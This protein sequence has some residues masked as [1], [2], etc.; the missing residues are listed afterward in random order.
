MSTQLVTKLADLEAWVKAAMRCEFIA[1]DTETDGIR[2]FSEVI[3]VSCALDSTSAF[4]VPIQIW[5]GEKLVVPWSELAYAEVERLLKE[6]FKHPK[7]ITHNGGFDAK[8]IHNTFGVQIIDN[9]FCDTQLLHHTVIDESPPHGL[10]DLAAKHISEDAANPQLDLK[11]SVVANGGKWIKGQRDFYK[12]NWELLGHYA[13][14]DTLYTYRLFEMWYP[15]IDKQGLRE[16][17]DKEVMPLQKVAYEMN[18]TGIKVNIPYFEKLKVDMENT[19]EALA[20]EIYAQA[21]DSIIEYEK[22][23]LKD[24]LRISKQSAAGKALLKAGLPLEWND[25]TASFLHAWY[26]EH[27]GLK[28]IF[29]LEST[30]DKAF[31]LYNVLKLPIKAYTAS[32]KPSTNKAIIDEL[33]EEYEDSSELLKLIKARSSELKLL[34]TYVIPIL[35]S[36]EDGKIYPSF[37][38]TGTTSGRF[39]CGGDSI[40]LQTL[41]RS[42]TRIKQGFIP[43]EG[44]AFVAADY[45]SLEPRVFAEVSGEP[46][47]QEIFTDGLDFYSKI[48][49]DVL[50]LEG[51][52][53]DPSAATYLGTVDKEKRQFVKAFALAVPYGAEGGRIAQLLKL[54]W[55]EGKELVDKYL[56]AYPE[57]SKWMKRSVW[58]MKTKGYVTS[59]AGR[60]KRGPIVHELH[61]KYKVK[62][63]SKRSMEQVFSRL[64]EGYGI[65]DGLALYLECRNTFN[66]SRNHQIQSFAASICNTAMIV[67]AEKVKALGLRAK[68]MLQIHDEIVTTCPVEEVEIVKKLLQESMEHNR[69]T[70]DMKVPLIAEPVDTTVSLAEAK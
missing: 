5:D 30:D 54:S 22:G 2:R 52:S 47:I 1:L 27:K 25:E 21:K 64:P 70:K 3:G 67:F 4:Y 32:G 34:S 12:G 29:N 68:V 43:D 45:S 38:Q 42:D 35:E 57:L 51:V 44:H 41:P 48:A 59:R 26:K 31:L 50:G 19:I 6:L 37:M 63:F 33:I 39:S 24:Q 11:E 60:K 56:G 23:L 55:E 36:H 66:V 18:T 13:C 62:D 49:I 61:T 46:G 58:D 65:K 9:I 8:V 10:K 53:A 14:Y 7:I 16:L 69:L 28:T 15:E 17:W 20:D 40:N